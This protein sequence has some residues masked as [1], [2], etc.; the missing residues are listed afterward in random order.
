MYM[1]LCYTLDTKW[2]VTVPFPL[3][4]GNETTDKSVCGHGGFVEINHDHQSIPIDT[5]HNYG[6]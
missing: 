6:D 4:S 1:T 5:K 3:F 2:Y